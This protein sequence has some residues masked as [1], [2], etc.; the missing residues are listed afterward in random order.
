MT[1][2]QSATSQFE[3][4]LVVVVISL[5][6]LVALDRLQEIQELSEMT[7]VE[8]TLRNIS[9]GLRYTMAEYLIH[10]EERRMAELV[11]SNPVRWLEHPPAGYLGEYAA[12]PERLA[13]GAWFFDTTRRELCYRPILDE[14][15]VIAA[16]GPLLCWRIVSSGDP[17]VTDRVGAV[18][19]V[20][21]PAY[22]WF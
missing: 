5:L 12:A 1:G 21:V 10:G 7:V 14:H 17:R 15:L 20:A 22:R 3:F 9:S 13:R 19:V 16:G 18:R 6:S 4:L 11:G 8:A 2:R